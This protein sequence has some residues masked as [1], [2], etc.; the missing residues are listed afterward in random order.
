MANNQTNCFP[1]PVFDVYPSMFSFQ[2]S[3]LFSLIM[4]MSTI[5]HA[6]R[7]KKYKTTRLAIS[8]P[9]RITHILLHLLAPTTIG[10]IELVGHSPPF[11]LAIVLVFQTLIECSTFF[12]LLRLFQLH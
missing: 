5:N 4:Y 10:I 2:L 6:T 8:N 9:D 12:F 7:N 11:Q 1:F 3:S